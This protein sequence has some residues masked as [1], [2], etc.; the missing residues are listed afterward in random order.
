MRAKSYFLSKAKK[1][2]KAEDWDQFKRLRNR[3]TWQLRRAKQQYFKD[4]TKQSRRSPSKVWKELNRLL[5]NGCKQ[6]IPSLVFDS[7][8]HCILVCK[9]ECY[10]V[11]GCELKWFRGYMYLDGRRQRVCVGKTMSA[12]CEVKRGVP[13]GLILVPQESFHTVCKWLTWGGSAV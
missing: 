2:K 6:K 11:R 12:W 4:L 1:N 13:Q 10:G 9:L 5:G 8:E 3:V 7:V